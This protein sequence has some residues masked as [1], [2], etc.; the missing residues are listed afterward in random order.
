MNAFIKLLYALMIAASVAVFVGVGIFSFYTPPKS[1]EYPNVTYDNN[2]NASKNDQSKIDAYDRDFDSYQGREKNYERNV[3]YIVLPVAFITLAVGLYLMRKP[4]VIGEGLALGGI[5]TTAYGII[6]ASI[7]ESNPLRFVGVA[8]LLAGALL[9]GQ[10]R[11]GKEPKPV[12]VSTK[13][14]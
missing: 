6:T 2:G 8:L 12:I 5:L 10:I 11:F 4:G 14:R 9:L 1:P 13:K 7:A 3:T